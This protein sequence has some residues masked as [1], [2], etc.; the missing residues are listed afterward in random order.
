MKR[1]PAIRAVYGT[2][3][4]DGEKQ[5]RA[6]DLNGSVRV[7]DGFGRL[8]RVLREQEAIARHLLAPNARPIRSHSGRLRAIQLSAFGDDRGDPGERHGSSLIFTERLKNDRGAYIG[9]RI[10]VKHKDDR[11]EDR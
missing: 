8:V 2:P 5:A 4:R 6:T 10:R 11:S 1:S 3:N 7:I 9:A